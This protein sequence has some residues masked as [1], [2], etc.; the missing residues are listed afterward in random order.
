MAGWYTISVIE[1]TIIDILMNIYSFKYVCG[2]ELY[3]KKYLRD[4]KLK[5][6]ITLERE[7]SDK[8]P[9]KVG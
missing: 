9:K 6:R 3:I 4:K 2:F 7:V 1:H 8:L 5:K